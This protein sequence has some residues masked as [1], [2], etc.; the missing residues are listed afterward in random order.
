M[1]DPQSKQMRDECYPPDE[2]RREAT[3]RTLFIIPGWLAGESILIPG[4]SS[5]KVAEDDDA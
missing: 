2:I 1:F 3:L 4:S 5:E